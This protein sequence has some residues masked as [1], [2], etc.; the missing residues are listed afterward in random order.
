MEDSRRPG[1]QALETPRASDAPLDSM[2]PAQRLLVLQIAD[3][4]LTWIIS[5]LV[6]RYGRIDVGKVRLALWALND[7]QGVDA[8]DAATT[9]IDAAGLQQLY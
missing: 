9:Q 7:C 5:W 1:L 8:P 6:S 2:R 4:Q 3:K